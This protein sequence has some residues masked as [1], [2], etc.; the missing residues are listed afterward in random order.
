[1][2]LGG[3]STRLLWLGNS[4]KYGLPSGLFPK[5]TSPRQC[6]GEGPTSPDDAVQPPP[7]SRPKK[8]GSIEFLV[9]TDAAKL[10]IAERRR[11]SVSLVDLGMS[12]G[13]RVR[14]LWTRQDLGTFR[15]TFSAEIPLHGAGLFRL[16]PQ[17]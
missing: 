14:D 17:P 3:Q 10:D 8:S 5:G 1:M 2:L 6:D 11:M 12:G 16:S 15:G 4:A 7:N 13:A 9:F